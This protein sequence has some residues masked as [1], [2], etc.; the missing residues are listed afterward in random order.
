MRR[1]TRRITPYERLAHP[2]VDV[3]VRFISAAKGYLTVCDLS[4]IFVT[5]EDNLLDRYM[6]YP[7]LLP[8]ES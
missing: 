2:W 7:L 6:T 8:T 4:V 5:L 3:A 1:A